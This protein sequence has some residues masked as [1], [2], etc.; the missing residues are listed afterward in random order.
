[1]P[2]TQLAREHNAAA[3][4][5]VGVWPERLRSPQSNCSAASLNALHYRLR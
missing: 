3:A 5:P 4:E 1:M 2:E